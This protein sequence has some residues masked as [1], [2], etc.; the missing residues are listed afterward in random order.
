MRD[1][2]TFLGLHGKKKKNQG[3]KTYDGQGRGH[4]AE[5][6]KGEV[7]RRDNW[8]LLGSRKESLSGLSID[9]SG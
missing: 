4:M 6:V 2:D 3:H 5:L 8:V 1:R 7:G 9:S